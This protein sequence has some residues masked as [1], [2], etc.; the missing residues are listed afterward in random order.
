MQRVIWEVEED[1]VDR[2]QPYGC[3]T[4]ECSRKIHSISSLSHID[5]ELLMMREVSCFCPTCMD[6][7]EEDDCDN[8]SHV[9]PWR[10]LRLVLTE[11]S[12]AR[13]LHQFVML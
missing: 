10:T 6:G 1:A 2:S 7:G 9:N 5:Y 13:A 4:I 3:V 12:Q 11:R 8:C